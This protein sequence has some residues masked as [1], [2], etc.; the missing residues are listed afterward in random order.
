MSKES[1]HLESLRKVVVV[2][3]ICSSTTLLE[4]LLQ[5]ENHNR[6]RDLLIRL[7]RF[8]VEE[9]TDTPFEIYKFLGDG[10]ILLFDEPTKGTVLMSFLQ[11]LCLRYESLFRKG[12]SPVLSGTT[13]RIGLTFG[14]DRGKVVRLIMNSRPEYIGRPLNLA[15]RLQGAIGQ[16]DKEPEG[17]VLIS[18][19]AHVHLRLSASRKYAGRLVERNLRNVIGGQNYQARKI[20]L[21]T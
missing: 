2:F 16:K 14:I 1:D 6:W 3:D 5:N 4:D 21:H 12:I 20:V 18:K 13:H 17:K 11:R 7:K 9:S 10:W 15:N 19:S 8:L